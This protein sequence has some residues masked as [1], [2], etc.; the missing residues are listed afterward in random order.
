MDSFYVSGSFQDSENVESKMNRF[1]QWYNPLQSGCVRI[2]S[3][4]FFRDYPVTPCKIWTIF[5]DPEIN[6][7]HV[8][9]RTVT[10]NLPENLVPAT[11]DSAAFKIF[12]QK[13]GEKLSR[14]SAKLVIASRSPEALDDVYVFEITYGSKKK[15]LVLSGDKIQALDI[16]PTDSILYA[17]CTN[18]QNSGS[19]PK[20]KTIILFSRSRD[21]QNVSVYRQKFS[22]KPLDF[23]SQKQMFFSVFL[24]KNSI[25]FFAVEKYGTV[26]L[27]SGRSVV[28]ID[29]LKEQKNMYKLL[30]Y[31]AV[32]VMIEF[33]KFASY[34]NNPL[35]YHMDSVTNIVFKNNHKFFETET[36]SNFYKWDLESGE[37]LTISRNLEEL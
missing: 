7:L 17:F 24:W 2:S 27:V 6:K 32:N 20:K 3:G 10:N 33:K 34:T 31:E 21:T 28:I 35:F 8:R 13:T 37:I 30:G 18:Q 5:M 11:A 36:S 4:V 1:S 9:V 19:Q 16:L 12:T 25:R 15:A 22:S 14:C 23:C 26:V 29:L